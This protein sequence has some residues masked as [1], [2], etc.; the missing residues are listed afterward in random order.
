MNI[1]IF[2]KKCRLEI[3]ISAVVLGFI[4]NAALF[5][6]CLRKEGMTNLS[7]PSM[8]NGVHTD[9]YN[10][11]HNRSEMYEGPKLP[12]P[13]GQMFMYANNTFKPECCKFSSV[14]GSTGCACVTK[15]QN[16]YLNRRGGNKS[17]GAF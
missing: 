15:E 5:C 10:K 8:S 14:S 13:E 1:K 7:E 3:I 16:E 17:Y 4:L 9:K 11:V 6:T 2:G 12:L